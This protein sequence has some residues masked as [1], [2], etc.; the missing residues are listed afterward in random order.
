MMRGRA[1]TRV[2]TFVG[3]ELG[4]AATVRRMVAGATLS[5]L[6]FCAA[7]STRGPRRAGLG[8]GCAGGRTRDANNST[9]LRMYKEKMAA[10]NHS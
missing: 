5:P 1:K 8:L 9:D 10:D 7:V 6:A 2:A 3:Q 4:S